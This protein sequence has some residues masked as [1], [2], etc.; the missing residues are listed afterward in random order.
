MGQISLTH[1]AERDLIEIYLFGVAEF[2][3]KQADRYAD[4]MAA[5]LA[6]TAGNPSFG[7]DYTFVQT[8]LRRAEYGAHAI[9]YRQ[10]GAGIL[11]L[12]ILHR[13]MDV[14]RH[15]G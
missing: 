15:L 3:A 12:R 8:G 7:A 4:E 2:G 14:G 5:K 1:A 13:R 10:T 6:L 9:Y 11:V